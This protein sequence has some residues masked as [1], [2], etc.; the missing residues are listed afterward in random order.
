MLSM[1][2]VGDR[3]GASIRGAESDAARWRDSPL[4]D[5]IGPVTTMSSDT[6]AFL[7]AETFSRWFCCVARLSSWEYEAVAHK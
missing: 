6:A 1:N 5:A 7:P 3:V 4:T 2:H